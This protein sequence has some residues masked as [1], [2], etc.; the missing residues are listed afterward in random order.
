MTS[1][2]TAIVEDDASAVKR[3][4][5]TD[6]GLAVQLIQT[7]KLYDSGIFQLGE[8][9][10]GRPFPLFLSWGDLTI[11]ETFMET[12]RARIGVD[13]GNWNDGALG[14]KGFQRAVDKQYE[15]VIRQ[16]R[17][18]GGPPKRVAL[19]REGVFACE[20]YTD[21]ILMERPNVNLIGLR[22]LARHLV[23]FNFP[24]RKLYL[25]KNSSDPLPK[26][27]KTMNKTR[28]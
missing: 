25:K 14:I 24:D 22:F 3:L 20:R 7:P 19:F 4:L 17:V 26:E 15:I 8:Q 1:L 12:E 6:V 5:R 2:L 11:R 16:P 9:E 21:L 10:L 18:T 27:D 13:T 23:T 28:L